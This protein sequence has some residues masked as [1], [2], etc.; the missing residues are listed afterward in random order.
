MWQQASNEQLHISSPAIVKLR[1]L[2]SQ[3]AS[4]RGEE[5]RV[6]FQNI[7]SQLTNRILTL[8]RL[9]D[10]FGEQRDYSE[11]S[12]ILRYVLDTSKT[13]LDK[14]SLHICNSKLGQTLFREAL[15]GNV[16]WETLAWHYGNWSLDGELSASDRFYYDMAAANIE[17]MKHKALV[18]PYVLRFHLPQHAQTPSLAHFGH[19]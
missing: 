12:A 13:L 10:T 14:K 19:V 15:V 6:A 1:N 4:N 3:T 16:T 11:A 2:L 7:M 9:S 5:D 18:R 8:M 17:N